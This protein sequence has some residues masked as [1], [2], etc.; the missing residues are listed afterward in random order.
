MLIKFAKAYPFQLAVNYILEELRIGGN[1]DIYVVY[2]DW[3]SGTH[4]LIETG[5]FPPK[6]STS[7]KIVKCPT[8]HP[9]FIM[10][11]GPQLEMLKHAHKDDFPDARIGETGTEIPSDTDI[12]FKSF[13]EAIERIKL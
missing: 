9:F 7:F 5:E 8:D 11:L 12:L 6:N 2:H 4:T 3:G 10:Q 1:N 13:L